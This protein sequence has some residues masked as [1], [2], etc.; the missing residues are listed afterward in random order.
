MLLRNSR[1]V[2]LQ[3]ISCLGRPELGKRDIDDWKHFFFLP[4]PQVPLSSSPCNR[5]TEPWQ[6]EWWGCPFWNGS[7]NSDLFFLRETCNY[8]DSSSTWE[9]SKRAVLDKCRNSSS[10]HG[11]FLATD[12]TSWLGLPSSL[13]SPL[14]GN[15]RRKENQQHYYIL[16][17][18]LHS[19]SL[20][21]LGF[22]AHQTYR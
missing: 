3:S 6:W 19:V 5:S 8:R 1:S 4:S 14:G 17:S 10:P 2:G 16:Y 13:E 21:W 15:L 7:K 22:W 18:A 9:R 12:K 11:M 20:M